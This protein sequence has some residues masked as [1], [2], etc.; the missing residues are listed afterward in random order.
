M[1]AI[2]AAAANDVV[3]WVLLAGVAAYASAAIFA[4]SSSAM[5]IGGILALLLGLCFIGRPGWSIG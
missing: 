1:I 4:R 5:Q 2:T 3:G